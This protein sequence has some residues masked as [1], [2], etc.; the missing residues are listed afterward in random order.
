MFKKSDSRFMHWVLQAILNWEP[1]PLE[2]VRV[3]QIHGRRDLLIRARNV[4]ADE[5]VPD[6]GHLI[7]VTHAKQVNAFLRKAMESDL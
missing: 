1:T 4:Q 6:G 7:N 2:G 5:I 3:L